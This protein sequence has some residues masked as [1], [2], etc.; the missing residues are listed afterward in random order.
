MAVYLLPTVIGVCL[1]W[2]FPRENNQYGVLFGY[3][4]VHRLSTPSFLSRLLANIR[5]ID[6]IFRLLP[7]PRP[8]NALEQYGR[9]HQTGHRNSPRLPRILCWEYRRSPRIPFLGSIRV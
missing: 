5:N 4:I 6:R 7:R 2:K 1:L 9:L 3:Y 8:P